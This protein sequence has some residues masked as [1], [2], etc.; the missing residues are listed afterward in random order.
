VLYL[1][2]ASTADVRDAMRAGHLGQMATPL[3][4]NRLEP[5]VPWA[6]D[7]G[8]FSNRWTER[9]WRRALERH[10]GT[11]G[12]LF[13]VVP[14]VVADAAA[15]DELWARWAPVVRDYGYRPAY[16]MQNGCRRVP[17]DADAVFTGGDT[18]WKL[19]ASARHLMR[20][21]K[22]R[23]LW[24]HMGR[25]NSLR[26]LRLAV[27]DGYDSVDGTFLAYGPDVNLPRLLSFLRQASQPT[28][29][30]PSEL[31]TGTLTQPR[32]SGELGL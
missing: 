28:L 6:L 10:A 32:T 25:V 24:C 12:C 26:R 4:G 8:C 3:S 15:T 21:A 19:G 5:G 29:F 30:D 20:T 2:T 31:Q 7:N 11:P 13:A 22:A 1:A 9:Q 17:V 27:M 16:V 18:A 14:D 23:G